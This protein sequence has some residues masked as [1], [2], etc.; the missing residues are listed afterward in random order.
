[1]RKLQKKAT[2]LLLSLCKFFVGIA[3]IFSTLLCGAIDVT[4]QDKVSLDVVDLGLSTPP[5]KKHVL[6]SIQGSNT[7][8]ADLTPRL[9]EGFFRSLGA[10]GVHRLQSTVDNES[11]VVGRYKHGKYKADIRVTIAAH[12]SSTGFKA[13]LQSHSDIAASS[14][15]IKDGEVGSLRL[16]DEQHREPKEVIVGIDGLA[17]IVHPDNP[18]QQ[19]SMD[20]LRGIYIGK[21]TNWSSVGGVNA[22]IRVLA[23]DSKS[24]TYDTFKSLVLKKKALLSSARRYESNRVLS[25]NVETQ[26][27]AIGFV[28]LAFVDNTRAVSIADGDSSALSPT[29]LNV[30]TEDYPLSRRLYF[31]RSASP[32]MPEVVNAF[33]T[34]VESDKG[35]QIVKEGGFISQKIYALPIDEAY[36]DTETEGFWQRLNLNVRFQ[37]GTSNLDNKAEMDVQRLIAFLKGG[38]EGFNKIRFVGYSNPL[39]GDKQLLA[40]SLLRAQNVRWALRN[41]GVRNSIQT[42]AGAPVFVADPDSVRQEKNRRVE[43]WVQ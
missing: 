3:L 21:F 22:K 34:F 15:P 24:G 27:D 16:I 39:G 37:Q 43:V 18:V 13:L 38:N 2:I 12:G 29:E 23:R 11:V 7:L 30:A 5:E 42:K 17:V 31:Y 6:F 26:V 20:Q 32:K 8:G 36:A 35:Q 25:Q 4:A 14:R 1:M 10:T 19:L 33:L 40:L 41:E 9:V 28:G